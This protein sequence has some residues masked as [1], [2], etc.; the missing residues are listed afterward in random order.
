VDEAQERLQEGPC[1]DAIWEHRTV[2]IDD[3]GQEDRWPAFAAEAAALGIGSCLSLQLFVDG[4]HLGALNL[5]ASRPHAFGEES[6]HVGLIFVAHA[7]VA[8]SGAQQEEH[9]QRAVSSRDMIGQAK[10]ILMERYRLTGDQAFRL[11]VGASSRTNRRLLD[12]AEEL[13]A[14]GDLPD[15]R[16][17]RSA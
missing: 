10:G 4:D 16:P 15:R 7:A 5:Y 8:L 13:S 11:L 6:E 3:M 14:T 12:I 1:L 9:L 17:R 2:R